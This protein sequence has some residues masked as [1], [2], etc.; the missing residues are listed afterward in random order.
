MNM[1][2]NLNT[3]TT[4]CAP[5]AAFAEAIR[6]EIAAGKP[7]PPPAPKEAASQ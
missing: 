4:P 6:A 1:A 7:P 3:R 5:C 2:E